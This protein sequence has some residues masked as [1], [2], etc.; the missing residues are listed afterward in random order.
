MRPMARL[1]A[2]V[3]AAVYAGDATKLGRFSTPPLGCCHVSGRAN[4]G[5]WR[6]ARQITVPSR[7]VRGARLRW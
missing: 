6:A 3:A 7:S 2:V 1:W 4:L 5:R